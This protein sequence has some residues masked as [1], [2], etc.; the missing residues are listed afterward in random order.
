MLDE[1]TNFLDIKNRYEVFELLMKL[2]SEHNRLVVLTSHDIALCEEFC[3]DYL[4]I[5]LNKK[6]KKIKAS[7]FNLKET[8]GL[9]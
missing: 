1:P 4:V 7:S 2:A 5:D 9:N 3:N 8:F 6:V